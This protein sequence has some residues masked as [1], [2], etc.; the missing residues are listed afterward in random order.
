MFDA[1]AIKCHT[2]RAFCRSSLHKPVQHGGELALPCRHSS[3][4]D[5]SVLKDGF[6]CLLTAL[7]VV[8]GSN[9]ILE[10]CFDI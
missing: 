9:Q 10:F 3:R 2:L 4:F 8:L 6:L 5:T 7:T 1:H